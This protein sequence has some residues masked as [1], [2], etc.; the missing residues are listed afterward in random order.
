MSILP[1]Q[2]AAHSFSYVL[3]FKNSDV[4]HLVVIGY[5][6]VCS[7]QNI[8]ECIPEGWCQYILRGTDY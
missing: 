6:L 8:L 7:W 1:C 3:P 4:A 5:K 2:L